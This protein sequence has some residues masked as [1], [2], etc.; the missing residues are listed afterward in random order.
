MNI[1]TSPRSLLKH[2]DV[3]IGLGLFAATLLL[4]IPFRSQTLYHWDSVNFALA[5]EHFD[6]RLHQ[7]HPPGTFVIYVMF[8]R[9]LNWFLNEPNA[10]LVWISILSSGLAATFIFILGKDWFGRRVGITIALLMLS[11][12]LIWFHG[13][14]ALSYMLEFFWV[15]LLILSCF[16]AQMGNEKALFISAALMGLAGGIRPNTPVFL[17]PLWAASVP[18]FP[19]RK[20]AIAMAL[21]ACG[22]A[23]WAIPMVVMSGGIV[24]Y[25]QTIQ[26]WGNQHV[27]SSGSLEGIIVNGARFGIFT[28][29]C[30]GAGL[31]PVLWAL[32]RHWRDLGY[33]LLNDKRPQTIALWIAPAAAYFTFVHLRQSGHTFTIM[34]AFVIVAGVA[35][36]TI[37]Q[38]QA[39]WGRHRWLIVA[40]LVVVCNSLFFLFGPPNLFGSSRSIF[41]AP[42]WAAIR[43]Y[44]SDITFRLEAIRKTFLPEETAVIA[45]SRN[46]RLPDFYLQDFQLPSLSHELGDDTDAIV[47]PEHVR[48]LVLFDD[49]V[50]PQLSAGP[51]L[52]SLPL[53]GGKSMRYVVWD[54]SQYAKLSQNSLEIYPRYMAK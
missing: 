40:V 46:Y 39:N 2:T 16:Q 19:V 37:C 25:W 5:L 11:S 26:W 35:T 41:S 23:L 38:Q 21:M 22:V 31:V 4:R 10:S 54:E 1:K 34:P 24:M 7:P 48:T 51:H 45:G 6:I 30:I 36:V 9:L 27:E 15:M 20:I 14:V 18:K 29:Y 32:Y 44:D 53:A 47:L 43:E 13:E 12:P 49:S 17:F 3:W 28:V 33:L 50:L 52:R 8:G 42:T